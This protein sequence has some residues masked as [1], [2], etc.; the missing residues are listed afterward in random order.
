M[1]LSAEGLKYLLLI[2]GCAISTS[3]ATFGPSTAS[4]IY[5]R[6]QE[7]ADAALT[8]FDRDNP[9]CQLWTNWQK[10]C[11]RT[12]EGGATRCNVDTERPVRP[13]VPFCMDQPGT[14]VAFEELPLI[15]QESMLRFCTKREKLEAGTPS[16]NEGC[17]RYQEDR[18]FNGRRYSAISN[19]WCAEWKE[20]NSKKLICKEGAE[21]RDS[22]SR[23]FSK[24]GLKRPVYCAAWT[25]EV[26][27]SNPRNIYNHQ[28]ANELL[29]SQPPDFIIVGGIHVL[30]VSP[31]IGI[32]CGDKRNGK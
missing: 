29:K 20:V 21:G 14:Y 17:I 11:S 24:N 4:D 9:S 13:S 30:D 15:E 3:C 7:Q 26:Q 12:G 32:Y 22:C 19:P 25:E 10:M 1:M 28:E 6:N 27:C 5:Y 8:A 16:A 23:K 18:P 2:A 31:I